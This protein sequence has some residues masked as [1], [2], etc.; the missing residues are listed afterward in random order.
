MVT[1]DLK[2]LANSFV[3]HR[4]DAAYKPIYF[5]RDVYQG[6]E[7]A[8][9]AKVLNYLKSSKPSYF[10]TAKI[11]DN[12]SKQELHQTDNVYT[13]GVYEWSESDIYHFENYN[14]P[15]CGTFIEHINATI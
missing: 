7:I 13:D 11:I 6:D 2:A 12:I 14:M 1:I 10:T 15:L 9:K 4:S 8:Q 5:K 3:L